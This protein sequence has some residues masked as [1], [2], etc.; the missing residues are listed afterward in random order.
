VPPW[1]WS[2]IDDARWGFAPFHYGRWTTTGGRWAWA[3]GDAPAKGLPAWSPATVAWIGAEGAAAPAWLP[4]G[5]GEPVF[6]ASAVTPAYW[7]RVN[8]GLP[9]PNAR[10]APGG[11][12]LVPSGPAVLVH[13][14]A[15]GAV[16]EES[17]D[18]L[19]PLQPVVPARGPGLATLETALAAGRATWQAPPGPPPGRG[20]IDAS[21]PAAKVTALVTAAASAAAASKR[22]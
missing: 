18:G 16:T 14:T 4:L 8:P 19:Q 15:K 1:G 9:Y 6:I 5:P 12:R 10:P 3:P 11:E 22:P 17:R 7:E 20:E 2:W 13:A 21:V